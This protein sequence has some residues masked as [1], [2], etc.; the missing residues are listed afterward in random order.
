MYTIYTI[1]ISLKKL[2]YKYK[3]T[4]TIDNIYIIISI[5]DGIH[6]HISIETKKSKIVTS[7][8]RVVSLDFFFFSLLKKNFLEEFM[9]IWYKKRT[10]V[11][12]LQ[13]LQRE[14]Q[15]VDNF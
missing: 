14:L 12:S 11:E 7:S 10:L 5:Y 4:I 9:L 1:I 15:F 3:Y 6:H 2:K 8:P 13:R